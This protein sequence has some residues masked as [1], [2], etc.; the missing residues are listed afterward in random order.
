MQC[1]ILR[2]SLEWRPGRCKCLVWRTDT[3]IRT[4]PALMFVL[5]VT[6]LVVSA[7][8]SGDKGVSCLKG[9]PSS[10]PGPDFLAVE[11]CVDVATGRVSGITAGAV[12]FPTAM[13]G[14]DLVGC[15]DSKAP[16]VAQSSGAVTVTRELTCEQTG[17]ASAFAATVVDKFTAVS[18]RANHFLLHICVGTT[19]VCAATDVRGRRYSR[20]KHRVSLLATCSLHRPSTTHHITQSMK[21]SPTIWIVPLTCTLHTTTSGC[22]PCNDLEATIYGKRSMDIHNHKQLVRGV[23]DRYRRGNA[24]HTVADEQPKH[25]CTRLS[26]WTNQSCAAVNND[27]A[28]LRPT[29]SV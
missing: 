25:K 13:G 14:T 2:H 23:V 3:H 5:A 28:I 20:Y 10:T 16:V 15:V 27:W 19:E 29:R 17:T 4:P 6:A 12:T 21:A 1:L 22:T 11:V 26:W 18:V 7:G 24:L 8:T 9:S